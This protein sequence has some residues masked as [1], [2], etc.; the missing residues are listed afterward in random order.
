MQPKLKKGMFEAVKKNEVIYLASEEYSIADGTSVK[1][2]GEITLEYT[3]KYVD[4]IVLIEEDLIKKTV[5]DL[6]FLEKIVVEGSG[7][8]SVSALN[9]IETE[10][11]DIV[12]LLS[13]GNIDPKLV[14]KIIK[15]NL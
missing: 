15:E 9:K 3:K 7:V 4:E 13:G 6:I 2:V 12:C 8:L 5:Y 14:Q 10:G 11:K 1:K